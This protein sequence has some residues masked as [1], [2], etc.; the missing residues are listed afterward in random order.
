MGLPQ[1]K[2][3]DRKRSVIWAGGNNGLG[4]INYKMFFIILPCRFDT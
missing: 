1:Y 2:A 3:D 4:Y